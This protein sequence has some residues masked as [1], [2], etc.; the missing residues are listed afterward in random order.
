[1]PG[2]ADV[3]PAITAPA[4]IE[5]SSA[6]SAQHSNV[7]ALLKRASEGAML[8]RQSPLTMRYPRLHHLG[9]INANWKRFIRGSPI[10]AIILILTMQ[11]LGTSTCISKRRTREKKKKACLFLFLF[12]LLFSATHRDRFSSKHK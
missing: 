5:I 8:S 10:A 12:G 2:I 6:G 1:M 7:E 11:V 3:S 9:K 4:P